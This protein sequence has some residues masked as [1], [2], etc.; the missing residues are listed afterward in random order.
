[1][2]LNY[3]AFQPQNNTQSSGL[4]LDALK[5][6][7]IPSNKNLNLRAFG[8]SGGIDRAQ[9]E[10]I[11]K[12]QE[13][14]L[15]AEEE[16]KWLNSP[17]GQFV[18]FFKALPGTTV[19]FGTD[20]VRE[21]F[22]KPAVRVA[23]SV[24]RAIRGNDESVTFKPG[25]GVPEVQANIE[26]FLLG[27]EPIADFK[28]ESKN[29]AMTFGFDEKKA[30]EL[31][32]PLAVGF[33]TLDIIP[34]FKVGKGTVLS[35]KELATTIAKTN[36][37][38]T[39]VKE[40]KTVAKGGDEEIRI[41][42]EG[43]K[44]M[45]DPK[46]ID[47]ILTNLA[48]EQDALKSITRGEQGGIYR[49]ETEQKAFEEIESV[50]S[51]NLVNKYLQ[52]QENVI[53]PDLIRETFSEYKGFNVV[54]FNRPTAQLKDQIYDA[55]LESRKG[56]GNNTVLFTGGGAGS[57]KSTAVSNF[58]PQDKSQYSIVFDSTLSNQFAS[59]EVEKAIENGYSVEFAFVVRNPK[60]AWA[61]GVLPRATEEGRIV[62]ED[63][64]VKTHERSRDQILNFYEKYKDDP[65]VSFSF[66]KNEGEK[67]SLISIDEVRGM[68]YNRSNL[69]DDIV[70]ATEKA[71][72][73]KR[74][75]KEQY[76]AIKQD[77]EGLRGEV[78]RS[79]ES[80]NTK[81]TLT[82]TTK[83]RLNVVQ[84]Q[85]ELLK[86]GTPELEARKTSA[87]IAEAERSLYSP[88]TIKN[89]NRLKQAA[90]SR[91][92]QEGDIETLRRLHPKILDD[93]LSGVREVKG[94]FPEDELLEIAL[95]LP[96][97]TDTVVKVP[98]E[99]IQAR[100]LNEKVRVFRQGIREGKK[101]TKEEISEIQKDVQDV[102]KMLPI[103]ERGKLTYLAGLRRATT[104][105]RMVKEFEKIDEAIKKV[106]EA[107]E[108]AKHLG[109]KRSNIAFLRK[110]GEFNQTLIDDVKKQLNIRKVVTKRSGQKV[111]VR[112]TIGE[113]TEPELQSM[114]SEL[115]NRLRFKEKRGFVPTNR[116]V[117]KST[118][119]PDFNDD[120]Y[121]KNIEARKSDKPTNS[122][123]LSNTKEF[124]DKIGGS[125]ST[126]LKNINPVLKTKIRNYEYNLKKVIKKDFEQSKGVL[127]GFSDI[128]KNKEDFWTLDLALKNGDNVKSR[129]IF[130]KYGLEEEYEEVRKMLDD[131]WKRSQEVNYDI[132]Y[133]QNYF[134]RKIIDVEGFLEFFQKSEDWSFLQE[135]I[136]RRS[137]ELGRELVAEE[138]ANLINNLVRGYK[139]GQI[140]L[141][142]TGAMK[143]RVIDYITPELN[144]FYDTSD[145]TLAFYIE[146]M[147]DAI[148]ARRFFGKQKLADGA[149]KEG[150]NNINDSIGTFIA[151]LMAKGEISPKKELELRQILEARFNVGSTNGIISG[152]KNLAYI[153]TLGNVLNS[154]T[155]IGD[156]AFA[157]YKSKFRDGLPAIARAA[158]GK[159]KIKKEE[160]GFLSREITTEIEAK[161]LGKWVDR[162][163]RLTGFN[164]IDRIG[165]ESLINGT[166]SKAQREATEN[167]ARLRKELEV[168]FD[169]KLFGKGAVDR[170]IDELKSGVITDD[171]KFYAFNALLDFT[172]RAL[173]EMPEQYLR[174]GNARV[175]Y[176]LK[177]YTLKQFDVYR[178]E[179]WQVMKNDKKQ[180]IKN[181][182]ELATLLFVMNA[183]ADEIKDFIKGEDKPLGDTVVNNMLKLVGF[184]RYQ[185]TQVNRDGPSSIINDQLNL[186][187]ASIDNFYKDANKLLTD[188][189]ESVKI[190]ELRSIREIPVGGDLYYW[191]F[192]AGKSSNDSNKSK[193]E[194]K[195]AKER[196]LEKR[197]TQSKTKKKTAKERL[198]EKRGN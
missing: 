67:A 69:A 33:A 71:Y 172:P 55:L 157:L 25:E 15:D 184:S 179:I 29:L 114:V 143:E 136:D 83:P 131:M 96:K 153:D 38:D 167:S 156:L 135:A 16:A 93:V 128:R 109:R 126:R 197:G 141:S 142:K 47:N 9:Q 175:L 78:P 13:Q 23:A 152:Y 84:K 101:I 178:N 104:P 140:T 58:L 137:M 19:D 147:N 160:I 90:K 129:E 120:F 122:K 24:E 133:Q 155:Q 37:I 111:E 7:S 45:K 43:F 154:V 4:K 81:K 158:L 198:L 112:K 107:R 130:R 138:R 195:S 118:K 65:N 32:I 89:I 63:Y 187:F 161:G 11:K 61:E 181:M 64:F 97:K 151:D 110:I 192:G 70:E 102:L 150:L 57:G 17:A 125:I 72:E 99:I 132:G 50:G 185:A 49:T 74:I 100:Q 3:Q 34:P 46:E 26:K 127:K 146:K 165:A 149:S 40:L 121:Q 168:I 173:S 51:E 183:T 163:F 6:K 36:D 20:L 113:M 80:G 134:P 79:I 60:N 66:F 56:Q 117:D 162:I 190:N 196:L 8:Q 148:E 86:K 164:Q 180:G 18:E 1:M 2:A 105:G 42:A 186:P 88:T 177:T 14:A 94:D 41:F 35:F 115:S 189:D 68:E 191:W 53:N 59:R 123:A 170:V 48:K 106:N 171:V 82:K 28:T 159:S 27:D 12:L 166:V 39:I 174:H 119:A 44:N 116:V 10:K 52:E 188:Y 76:E 182:L 85:E 54:D 87:E 124:V 98:D 194:K 144:K 92:F 62:T 5:T 169:E 139:G 103:D 176:M 193:T 22:T 75:T 31:S 145:N 73:E 91:A 77:R 30:E 108:L 95:G 21:I